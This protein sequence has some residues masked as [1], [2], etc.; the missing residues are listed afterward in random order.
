MN[1]RV[2]AVIIMSLLP[3]A[4]AASA[5][6]IDGVNWPD[7]VVD[8]SANIQNYGGQVM[9]GTT[10]WWLTGPP[11]ADVNGNGYAGD[12]EDQDT[13]AGWR[14][15]SANECISLYW[16]TGIADLAGDD[17]LIRLYSGPAAAADV[18]ASVD[19]N[20]FQRLGTIGGGLSGYLRD[21]PFEFGGLFADDVHY[22]KVVRT[23][24]GSQTGMFFD[25]FGGCVPEPAGLMLAALAALGLVGRRDRGG[26][27]RFAGGGRPSGA[28]FP[29]WPPQQRRAGGAR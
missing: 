25:S 16:E 4:S 20:V 11:D 12:P 6:I 10:E 19:G 7:D 22:V 23:A 5:E 26:V 9:D 28:V 27:R 14:G 1:P 2:I 15:A 29:G 3:F 17:L 13:V 24:A 8:H 21:E 18:F